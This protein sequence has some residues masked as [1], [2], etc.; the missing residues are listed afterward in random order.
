[1]PEIPLGGVPKHDFDTFATS[2]VACGLGTQHELLNPSEPE[3]TRYL[4]GHILVKTPDVNPPLPFTEDQ[5]WRQERSCRRRWRVTYSTPSF[6]ILLYVIV[7]LC[8]KWEQFT[9]STTPLLS[10]RLLEETD[11][12]LTC[13]LFITL[14]RSFLN[15]STLPSCN[16]FPLIK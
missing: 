4:T 16:W 3:T 14:F 8:S 5:E 10:I 15:P 7:G 9:R 11:G 12:D 2:S 6:P 13:Q 1:M